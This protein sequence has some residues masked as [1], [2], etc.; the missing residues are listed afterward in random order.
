MTTYIY[1]GRVTD[2]GDAPFPGAIPQLWIAPLQDAFGPDG[3]IHAA[4]RIPITLQPSG[5]F[6]VKLVA[7]VDLKPATRYSLRCE[8]LDAN[9]IVRGWAQWDFTAAIGGGSISDMKD[10]DITQVW[11]ST[12]PPPIDRSGIYWVNPVT[13]DIR[14][15]VS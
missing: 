8:W 5:A 13:G 1:A 2:F 10:L 7:S 12:S 15:W 11:V 9:G 3:G 14:E 6:T 4:R